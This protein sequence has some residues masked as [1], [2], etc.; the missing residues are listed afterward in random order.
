MVSVPSARC[1][2]D[3]WVAG[4]EMGKVSLVAMGV[5]KAAAF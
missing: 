3:C 4:R 5:V 1:V 2:G